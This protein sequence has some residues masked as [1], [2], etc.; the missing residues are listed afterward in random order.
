MSN[1]ITL[2]GDEI[3]Y[4]RGVLADERRHNELV[5][6]RSTVG[7]TRAAAKWKLSVIAGLIARMPALSGKAPARAESQER[8]PAAMTQ[9]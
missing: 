3:E 8:L 5:A 7:G 2:S 9:D 1:N 6:N 4:L